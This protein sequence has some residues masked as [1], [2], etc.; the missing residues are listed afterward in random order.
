MPKLNPGKSVV[1]FA[2]KRKNVGDD[3]NDDEDTE[4]NVLFQI[5]YAVSIHNA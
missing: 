2:V 3:D 1:R 5:A 4:T